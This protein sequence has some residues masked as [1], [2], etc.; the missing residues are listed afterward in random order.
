MCNGQPI[1]SC[2]DGC[3]KSRRLSVT[4]N[5]CE[6]ERQQR[7]QSLESEN[8][9][10]HSKQLGFCYYKHR[11]G[12]EAR[13]LILYSISS[14]NTERGLTKGLVVCLYKVMCWAQ[15]LKKQTLFK[16]GSTF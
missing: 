7:Q 12:N 16:V 8:T 13:A 6:T 9:S 11:E 10:V 4:W 15:F 3:A 5:E 14:Q 2:Q 1:S